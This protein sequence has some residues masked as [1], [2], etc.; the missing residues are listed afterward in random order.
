MGA[1]SSP[2]EQSLSGS[3]IEVADIFRQHI[4]DYRSRHK[5]PRAHLKVVG[6]ILNCRSAYLGGHVERCDQCGAERFAYNSCRNRHCPKCQTL[7]KERWL[8]A[9]KAELLPTRYFHIVFTLAHELNPVVLTNKRVVLK[10]LF[11]AVSETLLAFGANRD[12]GLGGKLGFIAI[13]HTWDQLLRDHFHLHC[14]VP[15]GALTEDKDRWIG[16]GTDFLFPVKALSKVFRGKFM[17]YLKK[18]RED[19]RLIFPGQTKHFG[20]AGGFKNLANQCYANNWVVYC[21]KPIDN[22]EYVLEY[23]GRYTH[24]IAI[25][26][27]RIQTLKDTNVTFS[28]KNRETGTIERETIEA[29]EF[30]RRFLL[31]VLPKGFM[32]IRHYGLFANRCKKKNVQ[33]CRELLGLSRELP[34]LVKQSV[35]EM[36]LKLT[37][38]DILQCPCCKKGKMVAVAE[39]PEGSG[40]NAFALLNPSRNGPPG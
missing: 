16:C 40:L 35:Q 29:V 4:D 2:E 21:P 11:D 6:D 17:D 24:R 10:I 8:E 3:G 39:I 5:M 27:N 15:A 19:N 33:K 28:Y 23:L 13:L 7:T 20:T 30:I 26:N 14:L 34:E 36:M 12:N 37:G 25:S 31:H 32:R 9:R 1:T 18:A 38:S 22:P